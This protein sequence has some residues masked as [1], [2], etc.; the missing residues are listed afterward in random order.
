M[1]ELPLGAKFKIVKNPNYNKFAKLPL[2]KV[3]GLSATVK[4]FT[5]SFCSLLLPC[6]QSPFA[7]MLLPLPSL[8]VLG[9]VLCLPLGPCPKSIRQTCQTI[10]FDSR[11]R[12]ERYSLE[13]NLVKTIYL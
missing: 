1:C 6:F 8:F 5:P 4:K 11:C 3:A 7:L 13:T 9:I 10:A 12:T 2:A